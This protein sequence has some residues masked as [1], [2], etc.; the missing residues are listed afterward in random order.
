M[1]KSLNSTATKQ[2]AWSHYLR[3]KYGID[4]AQWEAIS[5]AQ[6]N[7]CAICSS[8][9]KKRRLHLDHDHKTGKIRGLLCWN[10]NVGLRYFKDKASLLSKASVYISS[11]PAL[12]A[13]GEQD[14]E[15]GGGGMMNVKRKTK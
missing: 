6:G 12:E 10:C 8:P 1:T 9:P 3:R 2:K 11:P 15:V 13:I 7:A 14:V 5:N 4:E